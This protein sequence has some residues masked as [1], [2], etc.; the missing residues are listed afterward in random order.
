MHSSYIESLHVRNVRQF[1]KLNVKF[2]KGFNFIAGPNGCGKTSVLTCIS[3]C[4]FHGSLEHSRVDE[5][6]EYWVDFTSESSD[7]RLG[8]NKN[9]LS[10]GGYRK[11]KIKNWNMPPIDTKRIA[12]IPHAYEGNAAI[13]CPLFLGANRSVKYKQIS[14]MQREQ[15]LQTKRSSYSSNSTRALYGEYQNDI[16][17]WIINRDFIIEK[18]WAKEERLNWHH[19]IASLP[20]IA[21]FDSNFSYLRT[22]RDLEPVFS[23]YGEDCYLE[24]LSSGFQA[25]LSIIANIF[26]WIEGSRTEGSR[27]VSKASGTVLIDELDL[28]LHP[29][30]QF[31]LRKGLSNIFPNLQFIVTTHSPHLLASAEPGEVIAMQKTTGI[32]EYNL[33]PTSHTYSG[34]NTDQILSE[35]MGVKSL[36]N[37]LYES[38]VN[39][40]FALV[41]SGSP[42]ELETAIAQLMSVAHPSDTIVT[43]LQANLAAKVATYND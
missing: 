15:E 37:K 39:K 25:I 20:T 23:I 36:E 28:H 5:T 35:V 6:S 31:T 1:G 29:E 33:E 18:E 34:W 42:S 24:E 13:F 26:E 11:S 3:H 19:L 2:N 16:K 38:L 22:G 12:L 43:V 8:V 40:A 32:K 41:E 4:F 21:P 9:S 17:Q 14:G 10:Q 27:N 30:W 7:Y